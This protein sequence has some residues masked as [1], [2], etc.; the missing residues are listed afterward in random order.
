MGII[1]R[2]RHSAEMGADFSYL[3]LCWKK[4]SLPTHHIHK[5]K[6]KI[7]LKVF[8]FFVCAWV[9][10]C[11]PHVCRHSENP[12]ER[13]RWVTWNQ[14]SRHCEPP[15][16][17]W[18]LNPVPLEKRWVPLTTEPPPAPYVILITAMQYVFLGDIFPSLKQFMQSSGSSLPPKYLP[19]DCSRTR[20]PMHCHHM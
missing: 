4:V 18:Q 10:F 11:V 3:T 5:C 2:G 12:D 17:C 20:H 1:L 14:S 16:R 13:T 8:N 7:T 9:C 15:E 19:G 6:H